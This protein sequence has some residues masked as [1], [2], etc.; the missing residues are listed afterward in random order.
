MAVKDNASNAR[1]ASDL[2]AEAAELAVARR[3]GG[4]TAR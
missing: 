3:P 1:L 2:A 4:A